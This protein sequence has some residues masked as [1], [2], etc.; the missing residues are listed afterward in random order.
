M[1]EILSKPEFIESIKS[2]ILGIVVGAIFALFNFKPPSP[3]TLSG[4]LGIMGIF[5]GWW[6]ISQF[7]N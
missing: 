6:F 4:I 7:F 2:L 1:N 3:E 5:L